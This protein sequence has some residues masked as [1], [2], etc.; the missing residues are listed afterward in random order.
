MRKGVSSLRSHKGRDKKRKALLY[1]YIGGV[2]LFLLLVLGL[3]FLSRSQAVAVK[4]VQVRGNE[5]V[6]KSAIDAI[7]KEELGQTRFKLFSKNNFLLFSRTETEQQIAE[8]FPM[9]A[10]VTVALHG[11]KTVD[12]TLKEYMPTFLWCDDLARDRCY[13]MDAR[14]YVFSESAAF[15]KNV[16]FTYYGLID[17]TE[18]VGATYLPP[19]KFTELNAFVDSLKKLN[20]SPIGV[21]SRGVDDFEALLASGGSIL[22]SNREDFLITFENLETILSERLRADSDFLSKLDYI[23]VRFNSKAFV[24]LK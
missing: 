14:G 2:V 9:V 24:R 4:T 23:D 13:F 3:S 22:F 15:S 17:L 10:N 5:I 8:Q 19:E 21:N 18:P 1:K 20:L 16:L 7:V 12:V 11:L 6:P